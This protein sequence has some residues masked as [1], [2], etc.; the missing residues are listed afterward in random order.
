MLGTAHALNAEALH[1]G[2]GRPVG[3]RP[4]FIYCGDNGREVLARIYDEVEARDRDAW[5]TVGAAE[6][7]EAYP[8][9][10]EACMTN[11]KRPGRVVRGEDGRLVC[12][13]EGTERQDAAPM[14]TGDATV[15]A[16]YA[17]ALQIT[18][19][20]ERAYAIREIEDQNAWR[21]RYT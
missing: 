13:A 16:A 20:R 12:R 10:G 11:D 7:T 8:V 21:A 19:A 6:D 18:D 3:R 5:R 17:N 4:S 9:L 2:Q 14:V 15:D 1:D